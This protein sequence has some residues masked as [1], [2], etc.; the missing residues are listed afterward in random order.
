[1]QAVFKARQQFSPV[2]Y[3]ELI[4]IT[5]TWVDAAMRLEDRDV[6]IMARIARAQLRR[7]NQDVPAPEAEITL[8]V[9]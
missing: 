1:M 9:A 4:N 6:K 7:L 5:R 8:H 3:D 2:S